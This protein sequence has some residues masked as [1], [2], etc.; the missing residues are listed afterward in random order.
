[1]HYGM[2]TVLNDLKPKFYLTKMR[3]V[4]K[5]VFHEYV[6][7]KKLKETEGYGPD[8]R[9]IANLPP[10]THTELDFLGLY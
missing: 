8:M 5:K 6:H 9:L 10:F 3:S 7:C 1:M 2:E 4:V